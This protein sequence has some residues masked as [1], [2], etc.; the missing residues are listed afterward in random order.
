[1]I[2]MMFAR[3]SIRIRIR[4]DAE[5]VKLPTSQPKRRSHY[6]L[7]TNGRKNSSTTQKYLAFDDGTI[8]DR[9]KHSHSLFGSSLFLSTST[10]GSSKRESTFSGLLASLRTYARADGDAAGPGN[11]T[12]HQQRHKGIFPIARTA[13]FGVGGVREAESLS[14]FHVK[15]YDSTKRVGLKNGPLL[16]EEGRLSKHDSQSAS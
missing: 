14:F 8:L 3:N 10:I 1:M 11:S 9:S 15:R 6:F 16:P 12:A 7:C 13:S 4:D 5:V 2:V